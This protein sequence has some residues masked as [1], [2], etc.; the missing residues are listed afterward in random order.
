VLRAK[1]EAAGVMDKKLRDALP[2]APGGYSMPVHD[3]L[4]EPPKV[5]GAADRTG[6]HST[7]REFLDLLDEPEPPREDDSAEEAA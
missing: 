7:V 6:Q 5:L 2:A 4:F 3:G 1:A